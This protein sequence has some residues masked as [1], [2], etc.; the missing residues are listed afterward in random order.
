MEVGVVAWSQRRADHVGEAGIA[1]GEPFDE[2]VLSGVEAGDDFPRPAALRVKSPDPLPQRFQEIQL[3]ADFKRSVFGTGVV[4]TEKRLEGEV[5][6]SSQGGDLGMDILIRP[7]EFDPF[8][9]IDVAREQPAALRLPEYRMVVA[10][11]GRVQGHERNPLRHDPVGQRIGPDRGRPPPDQVLVGADSKAAR[12]CGDGLR[13]GVEAGAAVTAESGRI[14]AVVFMVMGNQNP[15]NRRQAGQNFQRLP[16]EMM[17]AGIDQQA[18]D[19][20]EKDRHER[21][22][23]RGKTHFETADGAKGVFSDQVHGRLALKGQCPGDKV[24]RRRFL[25]IDLFVTILGAGGV[26]CDFPGL[27]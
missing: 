2:A 10:V 26:K 16:L 13:V 7:E 6:Y 23:D 5:A 12:H 25:C 22:S 15:M 21:A 18:V 9:E 4:G 27:V 14:A 19:L 24:V 11:T 3:G 17:L 8:P 1:G 20:I